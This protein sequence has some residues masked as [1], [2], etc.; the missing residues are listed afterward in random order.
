[1]KI[2]NFT[3]LALAV[4]LSAAVFVF[5]QNGNP[6]KFSSK[7]LSERTMTLGEMQ[8][9]KPAPEGLVEKVSK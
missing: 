2:R 1:M 8:Q 3:L 9:A 6:L 5:A 4:F 7:V